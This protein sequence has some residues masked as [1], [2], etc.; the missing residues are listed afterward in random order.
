MSVNQI[1]NLS[2]YGRFLKENEEEV[3]ALLKDLLISVT[4]FFRDPE[5]FEALKVE[6]KKLLAKKAK[7]SDFRVWV[8]GYATGEEAYSVAILISE[9]LDELDKRLQVQM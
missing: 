4:N 7:G 1:N 8:T 2:D 5:A 9:C 3:K 6:L